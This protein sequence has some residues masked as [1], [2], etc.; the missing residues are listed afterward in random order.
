MKKIFSNMIAVGLVLTIFLVSSTAQSVLI[1]ESD[2]TFTSD[3]ED[4]SVATSSGLVWE[5]DFLDEGR[6]D[7]AKSYNYVLDK[8]EGTVKMKDTYEAWYNPS[9][10]RM[11][12]IDVYNSGGQTFQDYVL[13]IVVYYDSD[14]QNDF[15]DLRFTDSQG[16]D[17]YYWIGEKTI[18]E[19][20]N[21][22]VRVPQVST[23][24]YRCSYVLW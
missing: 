7:T 6:I 13:D 19:Q 18:V 22:L 4:K 14:M 11:K 17:L 12:I 9:W 23:R 15:D 1:A 10:A 20:A 2:T 8:T 3:N 24:T 16:N 5:D 21:I